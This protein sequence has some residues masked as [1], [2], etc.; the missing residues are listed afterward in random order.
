MEL[1]RY[2]F[3]TSWGG[4]PVKEKQ[5]QKKE[6]TLSSLQLLLCLGILCT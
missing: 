2:Q 3:V 5:Q 6:Y 4:W 1:S